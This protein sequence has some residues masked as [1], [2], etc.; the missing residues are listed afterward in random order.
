MIEWEGGDATV[1]P[2][3]YSLYGEV[4]EPTDAMLAGIDLLVIDLP[5]VGARYYTFIWT[6][7]LCLKACERLGI[8]V[9]VLD[10]P[11]P[12]GG[13]VVEGPIMKAEN[14]SFVGLYPLP[15]RHGMT[16]GE[17]GKYLQATQFPGVQLEILEMERWDRR[18][19][20]DGTGLPWALPSPNMPTLDTAIVYPGMCLF[21]GTKLSE[22]RGTTRPFEIF[23]APFLDGEILASRL[24]GLG[25]EGVYFRP[26]SFEPTFQKCAREICGGCHIHVLDRNAF[27]SVEMVFLILREI[28]EMAGD[29]M[30]WQDPPYEYVWDRR[31]IDLLTGD[32]ELTDWIDHGGSRE[33]LSER[34]TTDAEKFTRQRQSSLIYS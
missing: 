21:E 25:L 28:R 14:A 34:L 4:R 22:G 12:L 10:R 24:N 3:V 17:V 8:P 15:A 29:K 19:Y 1:G 13:E 9:L 2:P 6:M 26:Y 18:M 31:P 20:F 27:R 33:I 16:I 23:G 11:N 30:H 7:A 32:S 5:D